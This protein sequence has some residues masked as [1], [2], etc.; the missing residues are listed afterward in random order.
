MSQKPLIEAYLKRLRM[1]GIARSYEA[2]AREAEENNLTY[3]NFLL[4][5]LDQEICQREGN[6]QKNCVQKAKFPA[7]KTLETFDFSAVPE[8]SAPRILNLAQGEYLA[9]GENIIFVGSNGTGKTHLGIG[10]GIAACRRGKRVRFCTAPALVN[11]LI[12]ARQNYRLSKVEAAYN[13]LDLLVL[14]ELG[15]VPFPRD[16]AELLFNLLS[17]RYERR[18]TIVTTNLEFSHWPEVLGEETLAGALVDRLTHHAHIVTVTG[19]SYRFKQTLKR[20]TN[21]DF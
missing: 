12:E 9:R 20:A 8:L 15:F 21:V 4:T 18:S 7:L 11:E 5:V 19:D 1:S 17:S 2:L 16:G 14:D 13:R 3:E 10:L 6:L